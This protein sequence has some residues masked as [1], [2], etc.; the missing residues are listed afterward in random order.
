MTDSSHDERGLTLVE[1]VIALFI[2]TIIMGALAVVTITSFKATASSFTQL[3]NSH[4]RQLLEVYFPRDVLSAN[5]ATVISA[6]ALES[7]AGPTPPLTVL[8]PNAPLGTAPANTTVLQLTWQGLPPQ[9]TGTNQ[10]ADYFAI[11]YAVVPAPGASTRYQLKRFSCNS[12]TPPSTAAAHS[13]SE[14]YPDTVVAYGLAAPT[15]ST[16]PAYAQCMVG[17]SGND[18]TGSLTMNVTDLSDRAFQISGEMRS[19]T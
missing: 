5:D 3:N 1:V 13:Y 11:D 17:G 19:G 15:G 16:Y 18:C 6:P 10:A 8:C 12:T 9:S 2:L 4:D 7:G 14:L